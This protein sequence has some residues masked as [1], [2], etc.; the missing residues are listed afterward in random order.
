MASVFGVPVVTVA[1]GEP[2]LTSAAITA[3]DAL[4]LPHTIRPLFEG[5]PEQVT[6]PGPEAALLE[7]L[8]PA[9]RALYDALGPTFGALGAH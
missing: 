8:L 4:G 2:G 9:H 7:S 5:P 1:G 6:H 3:A